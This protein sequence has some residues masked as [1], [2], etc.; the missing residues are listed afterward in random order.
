M[1]YKDWK[2][3]ETLALFFVVPPW[4]LLAQIGRASLSFPGWQILQAREGDWSTGKWKKKN[5]QHCLLYKQS[6]GSHLYWSPDLG[7]NMPPSAEI[8]TYPYLF[9]SKWPMIPELLSSAGPQYICSF[10]GTVSLFPSQLA[11]THLVRSLVASFQGL[12]RHFSAACG[13]RVTECYLHSFFVSSLEP[14]LTS[15][16]SSNFV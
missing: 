9:I 7:L 5:Q 6:F 14:F 2:E 16:E 1:G 4:K 8:G 10:T 3:R 15:T 12:Q 11:Q 13:D